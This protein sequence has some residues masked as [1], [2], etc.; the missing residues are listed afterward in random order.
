MWGYKDYSTIESVQNRSLRY[1]LGVHRFA[2]KL[3]INGDVGWLPAKER[4]WCNML[5]YWNK[6]IHMDNSRICKKVFLWDYSICTNNWCA[7]VKEIMNKLGLTRNFDNLEACDIDTGKLLL[8][9]MYAR[10]WSRKIVTVPKLRTYVTFKTSYTVEKYV[11]FNLNRSERSILAQFR[12]GILPLRI[13]T[14]RYVSEKPEE[15]LCKVCQSGQIENELHFLFNCVLYNDFRNYLL[16]A[17]NQKDSFVLL[18]DVEKLKHLMNNYPRQIAKYLRNAF[19]K[20]KQF[21]YVNNYSDNVLSIVKY[22]HKLEVTY[23]STGP[24]TRILP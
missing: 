14:G 7:E 22:C 1:F 18:S 12:C 24:G 19:E 17:I 2:P 11:L 23:R 16:S 6:L 9:D 4:R 5:R 21:L 10:D 15:R 20:R 8:H 13:E 3:A